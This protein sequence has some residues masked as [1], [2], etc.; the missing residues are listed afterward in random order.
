VLIEFI[1]AKNLQ[2]NQWTGI[3]FLTETP[4]ENSRITVRNNKTSKAL[5]GIDI[6]VW[7]LAKAL[8]YSNES[9]GNTNYG[10]DMSS[11]DNI[12][13]AGNY[14]HNNVTAGAKSP[15]ANNIIYHNN[16]INLNGIAGL[17]YIGSNPTATIT[18]KDNNITNNSGQAFSCWNADFNELIL[19][20][21]DVT[22]SKDSYGYSIG[23]VGVKTIDVTGDNGKIYTDGVIVYH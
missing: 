3:S 12:E 18:V 13:V 19:K 2:N 14:L 4:L 7:G 5:N 6:K 23:A 11:N 9:F 17:V 16:N 20:D 21:N 10:I 22:G 8:I 15:N 1:E